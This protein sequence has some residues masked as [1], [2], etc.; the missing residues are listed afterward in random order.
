MLLDKRALVAAVCA[1]GLALG[2][3]SGG[4]SDSGS[5]TKTTSGA[6]GDPVEGGTLRAVMLSEPRNLDPA[7]MQNNDRGQGL[8]GNALFGT[9][10][11]SDPETGAVDY[12]LAE[13]FATQDG[14]KTFQL[15][16]RAGLKFTDGTPFDAEAVKFNWE[17]LTDPTLGS[18]SSQDASSIEKTDVVDDTTLKVTL[19]RPTPRFSSQV[20]LSSMNWI[21]SPEALAGG[22]QKFDAAPV[23]AGPFTLK[24]WTRGGRIELVKNKSY[25][26]APRPYLDAIT[27][28][29]VADEAQRL[30]TLSSGGAE[31]T[32]L[33]LWGNV[34]KAKE[35]GLVVDTMPVGGGQMLGYNMRKAPF[36]DVRAREAVSLALDLDALDLAINEGHGEGAE[37]MFP[38]TSPL[39]ND[40]SLHSFDAEKAQKLF[41]ELKAEGKPVSFT[42]T[43]FQGNEDLG[44][45]VQAQLGAFKNVTVEVDV[46]DWAETGRILGE[47]NFQMTIAAVNFLDPDPALCRFA[48]SQSPRNSMGF[49]DPELDKALQTGSTETS[50]EAR[51]AAY[52][53]A[54]ER[55]AEIVPGVFYQRQSFTFATAKNVGGVQLYGGGSL[56][57]DQLWLAK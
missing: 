3:C 5:S 17:R 21:A 20:I 22:A 34:N 45:A 23:G 39:Y 30:S 14:G 49:Q 26:D 13:D 40:V 38:K 36:D 4:D 31:V 33:T 10:M 29:S 57:A 19:V 24:K 46:A 9:L 54:T 18:N 37:K 28:T 16:L 35:A 8:V 7:V 32:P 11:T 42:F 27:V 47:H 48:C 2:A 53:T 6:S 41:D 1:L 55:I 52:Q 12:K 56:L 44:Q 15:K 51:Q 25:V 50:D 43:T